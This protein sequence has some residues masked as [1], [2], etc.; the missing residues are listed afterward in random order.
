MPRKLATGSI[1]TVAD[2]ER[3]YAEQKGG[4]KLAEQKHKAN[5]AARRCSCEPVL[6]KRRWD[7]MDRVTQRSVHAATCARWRMWMSEVRPK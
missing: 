5:V 1:F 6:V 7:G 4:D 3:W 2:Q